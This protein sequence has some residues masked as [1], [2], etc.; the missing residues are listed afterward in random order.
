MSKVDE[1]NEKVTALTTVV[2][3]I[4]TTLDDEIA[5]INQ[6][7]E[8]LKSQN[9]AALQPAID[10]LDGVLAEHQSLRDRITNIVPDAEPEPEL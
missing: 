5:Q 3:D 10:A 7:L 4:G 2:Q 1:L 8:D 6:A 9:D